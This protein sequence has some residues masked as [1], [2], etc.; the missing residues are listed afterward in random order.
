MAA[1]VWGAKNLSKKGR[2]EFLIKK[3]GGGRRVCV[4]NFITEK[5]AVRGSYKYVAERKAANS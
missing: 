2:I 5:N 4:L 1:P 3:G